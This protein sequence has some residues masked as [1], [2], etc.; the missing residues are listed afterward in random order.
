MGIHGKNQRSQAA[1]VRAIFS[2]FRSRHPGRVKIP[3]TLRQLAIEA[4]NSGV[5]VREVASAAGVS[6]GSVYVWRK[7]AIY[8]ARELTLIPAAVAI[9]L[10]PV[11]HDARMTIGAIV[12]ELPV[13]AITSSLLREIVAAMP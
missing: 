1:Q 3:V 9:A 11:D 8:P 5:S 6:V 12:I 2:E 13:V 10:P 7:A 4:V